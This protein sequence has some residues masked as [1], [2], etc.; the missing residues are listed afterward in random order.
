[1]ALEWEFGSAD[2]HKLAL[3]RHFGQPVDAKLAPERCFGRPDG[4]ICWPRTAV[5]GPLKDFKALGF[6]DDPKPWQ[7]IYG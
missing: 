4:A 5:L 1:M 7:E 6:F 2:G 3:E